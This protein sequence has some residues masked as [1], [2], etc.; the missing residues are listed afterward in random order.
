MSLPD[1]PSELKDLFPQF[2][3]V[4]QEGT[5]RCQFSSE[6]P[7]LKRIIATKVT[8]PFQEEHISNDSWMLGYEGQLDPVALTRDNF[9]GPF[10]LQVTL[11]GLHWGHIMT[12]LLPLLSPDFYPKSTPKTMWAR[13]LVHHSGPAPTLPLATKAGALDKTHALLKVGGKSYKDSE[14]CHISKY[15]SIK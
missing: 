9:D 3:G 6:L 5:L 15:W 14:T 1:P 4:L 2:L 13:Q 12:Q 10:Q 7:W 8:S 11:G